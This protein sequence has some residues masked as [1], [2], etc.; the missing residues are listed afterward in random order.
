MKSLEK[1]P[2]RLETG[3]DCRIL[4]GFGEKICQMIDQRLKAD[5][6]SKT[7]SETKSMNDFGST[8]T[9]TGSQ[10]RDLVIDDPGDDNKNNILPLKPVKYSAT[11][12]TIKK[13][14]S[15]GPTLFHNPTTTTTTPSAISTLLGITDN[16]TGN[17]KLS[18]GQSVQILRPGS[19]DIILCVD[20][21]EASRSTQKVLLEH[22][23]KNSINFDVRKLNIGDFLWIVRCK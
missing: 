18:S 20:N 4:Y 10:L 2:L 22:L 16:C 21:A 19:F 23:K 8:Q 17:M 6:K 1:Y 5:G 11:S 7:I 13:T 14:L 9:S 12:K 15:A 3:A